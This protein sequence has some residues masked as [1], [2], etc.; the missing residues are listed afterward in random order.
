MLAY[1]PHLE[2]ATDENTPNKAGFYYSFK[3]KF[4]P[5]TTLRRVVKF[6]HEGIER[7]Q[8]TLIVLD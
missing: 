8:T 4:G 2:N 1:F 3:I 5:R 6:I 7:C